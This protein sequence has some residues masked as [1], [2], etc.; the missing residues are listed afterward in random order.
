MG[1]KITVWLLAS[2]LLTAG[3]PAEAQQPK[4]LPH[5]G[6]LSAAPSIDPAFLEGLREHGYI[7]KQTILIEHRSAEGKLE[8]LSEFAADLVRLKLDIIVT[9]G[10]PAAQAA[11]KA[12]ATIPVVMATTGDAV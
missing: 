6:F 12:T 7:D 3:V 10:T 5:V 4:K 11:K 9:Q 8:K 2:V 1:G